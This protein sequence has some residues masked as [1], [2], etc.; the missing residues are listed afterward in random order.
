MS[1][2]NSLNGSVFVTPTKL[3]MYSTALEVGGGVL[4]DDLRLDKL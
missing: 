4:F 3:E 2:T 1:E